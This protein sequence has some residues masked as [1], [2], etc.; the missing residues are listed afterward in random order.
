MLC[1]HLAK[2][3]QSVLCAHLPKAFQSVLCTYL[4]KAFQIIPYAFCTCL[5]LAGVILAKA[6][7]IAE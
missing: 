3:F 7:L 6:L 1:V 4:P 2:A 5:T